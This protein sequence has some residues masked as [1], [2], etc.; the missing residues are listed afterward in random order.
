MNMLDVPAHQRFE[1]LAKA[2]RKECAHLSS[3]EEMVLHPAYQQIIGMGK[4]AIPFLLCELERQPDHWFWALWVITGEDPVRSDHRGSGSGYGKQL[5]WMGQ[6][7]GDKVVKEH[8]RR[9]FIMSLNECRA[10]FVMDEDVVKALVLQ[11][12]G[13]CPNLTGFVSGRANIISRKI[14]LFAIKIV[15]DIFAKY[16]KRGAQ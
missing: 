15:K 16:K 4:E 10:R 8:Q 11:E 1:F 13:K 12:L 7:E 14:S 3:V 5:A 2:W 6:T 9:K